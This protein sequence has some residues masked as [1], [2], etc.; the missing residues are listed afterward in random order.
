MADTKL[1][2]NRSPIISMEQQTSKFGTSATLATASFTIPAGAHEL[3]C[4]PS[5]ACHFRVNGTATTGD[6]SHAVTSGKMFV[7]PHDRQ[8]TVEI[9]GDGGAFTLTIAYMK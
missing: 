1:D 4:Y 7:I 5:A 3:H 8:T 2:T 9:I 6:G